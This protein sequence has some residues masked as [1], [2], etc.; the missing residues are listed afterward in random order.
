MQY[1][2]AGQ[3][4]ASAGSLVEAVE[5]FLKGRVPCR[6]ASV[7]TKAAA[8]VKKRA[9][10]EVKG[11]GYGMEAMTQ[12]PSASDV[13]CTLFSA[14]LLHKVADELLAVALPERCAEMFEIL[15]ESE[16]ALELYRLVL[17]KSK[18]VACIL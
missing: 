5:L 6:A 9:V 16:R 11:D 8:D 2:E 3:L 12:T 13:A 17:K 14:D 15:G 4:A 7:I 10:N 1:A 18:P